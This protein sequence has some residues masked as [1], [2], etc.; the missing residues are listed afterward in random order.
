MTSPYANANMAP[1]EVTSTPYQ[2]P[3]DSTYAAGLPYC[4]SSQIYKP[5]LTG[6]QNMYYMV[7]CYSIDMFKNMS[8]TTGGHWNN[9]LSILP[10]NNGR[11]EPVMIAAYLPGNCSDVQNN[12]ILGYGSNQVGVPIWFEDGGQGGDPIMLSYVDSVTKVWVGNA[13][14]ICTFG[15]SK[16]EN[17][18]NGNGVCG[19]AISNSPETQ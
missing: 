1:Y 2:F 4:P 19:N 17:Q 11:N 14:R 18:Y 9:W 7:G 6:P 13:Y 16:I 5:V 3:R 8:C 10:M 15:Y 12:S